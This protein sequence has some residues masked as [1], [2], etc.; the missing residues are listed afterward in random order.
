MT[1]CIYD[2]PAVCLQYVLAECYEI[3][4][5]KIKSLNPVVLLNTLFQSK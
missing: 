3:E 2:F 5:A 1:L 4:A